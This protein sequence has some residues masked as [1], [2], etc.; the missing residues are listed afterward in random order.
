[1]RL[2]PQRWGGGR[3]DRLSSAPVSPAVLTRLCS[4]WDVTLNRKMGKSPLQQLLHAH[5]CLSCPEL[6]SPTQTT[7]YQ[8]SLCIYPLSL[9]I[10]IP[11]R[12]GVHSQ[13]QRLN[14]LQSCN[15]S[16]TSSGTWISS[17]VN[18]LLIFYFPFTLLNQ[19]FFR[20]CRSHHL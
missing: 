18:L 10:A 19:T 16:D 7:L 3:T 20:S 12:K 15:K 14:C 9:Y 2:A 13:R 17:I 5:H 8:L 1:M 6:S 11:Y 4:P